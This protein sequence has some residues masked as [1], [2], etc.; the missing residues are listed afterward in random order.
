MSGEV[1][2]QEAPKAQEAAR[3]HDRLKAEEPAAGG[4]MLLAGGPRMLSPAYVASLQR[5]AG[6]AGM[7]S[8]L[9]PSTVQR[10]RSPP[11]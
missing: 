5:L 2:H 10:P 1:A 9:Q 7:A 3:D 11:A 8:L 6:N 4:A